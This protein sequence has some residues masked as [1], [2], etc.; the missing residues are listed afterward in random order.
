MLHLQNNAWDT[1]SDNALMPSISHTRCWLAP[2]FEHFDQKNTRLITVGQQQLHAIAALKKMALPSQ[3]PVPIA[4]TWNNGFLFSGTP[5]ISGDNP[6]A[7]LTDL[8]AGARA[9]LGAKAVLFRKVQRHAGFDNLLKAMDNASIAGHHLFNTHERAALICNSTYD[10]WFAENF[11]RKRRKEYRRLR[12]R[13]A[14]KGDLKTIVWQ[15]GDP[16]KPWLEEF[17]Q[18]EAAGWKGRH[19]TAIARNKEQTA[20]LRHALPQLAQ[21]GSLLFWKVTLD[22][23]PIALL[24]GFLENKQVWL[25]KMAFDETLSQY[26][27]GVLIILEATA[28]LLGRKNIDLVDSS[29]D[30][31][32]PMINN[33]WRDRV[34]VADYLIAT[35]GTSPATF[36][37]LVMFESNRL[38]ARQTAK[39]L[40]HKLRAGLKK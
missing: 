6:Q 25:G 36:N 35:P 2:M 38:K 5:L 17:L 39:T 13:L 40:Y 21:N 32:H 12:N 19:G 16:V 14:E 1:L 8:L 3:I 26:S 28:D 11:S 33:I 4:Q 34:Q 27:P 37:S 24:F 10:Q 29:A 15:P 7:A 9:E 31:D 30:P 22:Q 18:L 20:H 23:K